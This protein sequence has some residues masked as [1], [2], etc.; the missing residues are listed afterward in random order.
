MN[1]RERETTRKGVIG[2]SLI[3]KFFMELGYIIYKPINDGAHLIDYILVSPDKK[4]SIAV[5]IKTKPRRSRYPDTGIEQ[6]HFEEYLEYSKRH[7]I[8]VL[9]LFV[10]EEQGL[11]YGNSLDN[12]EKPL[13]YN[14]IQYPMVSR[15]SWGGTQHYWCLRSMD[16]V[17]ILEKEMI[18]K[19][20]EH[21]HKNRMYEPAS[22][23][24]TLALLN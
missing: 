12:L 1:F 24:E 20:K 18:N 4:T 11:I 22:L 8:K 9:I 21:T 5:D 7:N 15:S 17:G 14:G 3:E 19:I 23:A 13:E 10:D 16:I 6:C 2:E